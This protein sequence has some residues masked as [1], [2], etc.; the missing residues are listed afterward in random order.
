MGEDFVRAA[1]LNVFYLDMAIA[2]EEMQPVEFSKMSLGLAQEMRIRYQLHEMDGEL[3]GA[4]VEV[5][6]YLSAT[7]QNL[8]VGMTP[9][10]F[11]DISHVDIRGSTR[12]YPHPQCNVGAPHGRHI[13]NGLT[14]DATWCEGAG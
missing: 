5:D 1:F 8:K 9:T 2:A 7:G 10:G 14:S 6:R 3:L 11:V 4:V 12:R 13:I